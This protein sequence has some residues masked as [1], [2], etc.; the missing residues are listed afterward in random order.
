MSQRKRIYHHYEKLEEFKAGMW[1]VV[2]GP[3]RQEH[4]LNAGNLM[5]DPAAFKRAMSLAIQLWPRSCEANFTASSV[6]QIAWLGHAGCCIAAGST[7]ECT[8]LAWHTLTRPQ[9]DEANRVAAE[10][11]ATWDPQEAGLLPW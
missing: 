4:I 7:E 9:Q 5:R 2:H 3:K 8:R 1:Q 11:L 6:N 10:V